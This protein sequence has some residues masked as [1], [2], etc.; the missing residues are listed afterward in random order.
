MDDRLYI[1]NIG[2]S[3][4]V[5]LCAHRTLSLDV[6]VYTLGICHIFEHDLTNLQ[7]GFSKTN[8]E[9]LQVSTL[10]TIVS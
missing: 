1:V 10:S 2:R 7:R 8:F 5:T 9:N 6:L 4:R 3:N